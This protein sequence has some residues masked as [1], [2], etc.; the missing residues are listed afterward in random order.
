VTVGLV[1]SD[2]PLDRHLGAE[3][4]CGSRGYCSTDGRSLCSAAATAAAAT[5][6]DSASGSSSA[7]SREHGPPYS[8]G[9]TVGC[10]VDFPSQQVCVLAVL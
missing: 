2:S 6:A 4:G 5:T 9:D 8:A 1:S 10:G 7:R 3:G